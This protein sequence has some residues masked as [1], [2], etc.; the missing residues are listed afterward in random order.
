MKTTHHAKFY[1][2]L[3]MWVVSVN[4]QF[5]TV[6]EKTISE[7]RVS[8]GSAETLVTFLDTMRVLTCVCACSRLYR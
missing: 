7:V 4:T 8:S 5:A 1:F 3:T 6:T 2:D